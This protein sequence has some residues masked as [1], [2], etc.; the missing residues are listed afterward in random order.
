M[1]QYNTCAIVL[2]RRNFREA[3]RVYIAYTRDFGKLELL[4][5]GARKIESKLAAHLEPFTLTEIMIGRGKNFDHL[6]GAEV[7][8]EFA[9]IKNDFTKMNF[10]HYCFEVVEKATQWEVRDDRVYGLL[11]ELMFSLESFSFTDTMST[12]EKYQALTKSFV[13]KLLALLGYAPEIR[14]CL[15]CKNPIPAKGNIFNLK[16]G[17]LVCGHCHHRDLD[18]PNEKVNISADAIKVLRFFINSPT[19]RALSLKSNQ[20]PVQ[21]TMKIIEKFLAF[22]IEKPIESQ[23]FLDA[24]KIKN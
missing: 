3:D 16:R 7:V 9:N 10:L 18:L 20:S 2:S 17:G 24:L 11:L 5:R 4:A 19:Y 22:H 15:I 14:N 12:W 1:P 23:G 6:A 13:V 8:E 21:E